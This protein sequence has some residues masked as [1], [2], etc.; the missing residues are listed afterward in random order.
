MLTVDTLL[1]RD[2]NMWILCVDEASA[3][4]HTKYN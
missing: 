2:E 1:A 4:T 3:K